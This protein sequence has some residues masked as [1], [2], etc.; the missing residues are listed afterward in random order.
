M[1]ALLEERPSRDIGKPPALLK[2]IG[3]AV[4]ARGVSQLL[5]QVQ[6]ALETACPPDLTEV[7]RK[8]TQMKI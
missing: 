8:T 3:E 2:R 5:E 1:P 7:A 6:K 4:K